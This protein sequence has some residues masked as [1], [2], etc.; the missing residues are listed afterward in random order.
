MD[1]YFQGSIRGKRRN[2]V[3]EV[4]LGTALHSGVSA[5]GA[6]GG[7]RSRLELCVKVK[8]FHKDCI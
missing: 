3:T 6:W 8:P 4:C 2:E 7:R 1:R 5:A